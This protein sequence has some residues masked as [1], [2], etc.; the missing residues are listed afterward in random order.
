MISNNPSPED[1]TQKV[2]NSEMLR[3]KIQN[4]LFTLQQKFNE[5]NEKNQSLLDQIENEHQQISNFTSQF[6]I[7]SPIKEDS[8]FVERQ[9]KVIQ[10]EINQ[11]D[12][13]IRENTEKVGQFQSILT[14][15][16]YN[17][18]PPNFQSNE[19]S[20][21]KRFLDDFKTNSNLNESLIKTLT[22]L[23]SLSSKESGQIT[24][25]VSKLLKENSMLRQIQS[26]N[27]ELKSKNQSL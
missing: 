6:S 8:R 15:F 2:H 3:I 22:S 5:E 24:K 10:S 12:F 1:Y 4:Q 20:F 25:E 21:Y 14:N 13:K 19:P 11:R 7:L 16:V 23:L 9:I 17:E 26:E 18:K 27:L